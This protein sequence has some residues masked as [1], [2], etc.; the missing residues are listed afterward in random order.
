M[1][2]QQQEAWRRAE[3]HTWRAMYVVA[4]NMTFL[5]VMAIFALMAGQLT[6]RQLAF[7]APGIIAFI[8]LAWGVGQRHNRVAAAIL[9]AVAAV[10]LGTQLHRHAWGGAMISAAFLVV[11]GLAFYGTVVMHELRALNEAESRV[12]RS[13]SLPPGV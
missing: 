7:G 1:N 8:L 12:S 3:D 4:I 13:V 2:A 5:G 11:Y 10:P 6:V 9:V